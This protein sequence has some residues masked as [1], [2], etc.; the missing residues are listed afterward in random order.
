[1]YKKPGF[2]EKNELVICTVSRLLP[3]SVFVDLT[4]Y[5]NKEGMIHTSEIARRLVRTMRTYFKIGRQLVC[6][7][8]DVDAEKNTI[9]LSLRQVGASKERAK[10]NE[11][12]NEKKAHD[13]LEI[14]AKNQKISIDEVYKKVGN[15]ILDE[16]GLIY[17]AF[18]EISKEGDKPLIEIDVDKK[19]ASKL[20][21][22]IKNRIV[23]P[24]AIIQ[25]NIKI[26][27]QEAN[28]I[29]IIKNSIKKAEDI[30]KKSDSKLEIK[31]IGAPKYKFKLTSKDYKKAEEALKEIASVIE[32][33]ITKKGE[34]TLSRK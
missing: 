24:K 31:Y 11:F 33:E 29:E 8:I 18:I 19:I 17:P 13:I 28:G 2:P 9:S 5:E 4:E 23:I 26:S 25:G 15:K 10:I 27:S 20:A 22:L 14:F 16:Y 30:A 1:M 32:K 21:E 3:H 7:V 6:K 34:F 12:K